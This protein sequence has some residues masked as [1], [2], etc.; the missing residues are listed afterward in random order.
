MARRRVVVSFVVAVLAVLA[1]PVLTNIAT[2]ELPDQL[3]PYLKW[4]WVVLL[5]VSIP[6]IAQMARVTTSQADVDFMMADGGLDIVIGAVPGVDPF[7]T[8]RDECIASLRE[9]LEAHRRTAVQGFG[10]VGK[11]QLVARYI[12]C[13]KSEYDFIW[14]LRAQDA[15][16]AG[17]DYDA[18]AI[19]KSL[20]ADRSTRRFATLNWLQRNSRWLLIFDDAR[21]NSQIDRFLS[22]DLNGHVIIISRERLDLTPEIVEVKD[23]TIEESLHFLSEIISEPPQELK[24]LAVRLAGVPLALRQAANYI[25]TAGLSI[26]QYLDML[27]RRPKAVI[28]AGRVSERSETIATV[29]KLSIGAANREAPGAKK[30]LALCSLYA[31][32]PIPSHLPQSFGQRKM[33]TILFLPSPIEAVFRR[34]LR[35]DVYYSRMVAA[36]TRHLLL[37]ITD[38]A[39][40]VHPLIAD[41]VRISQSAASTRKF[42]YFAATALV[43]LAGNPAV[44]ADE[45]LMDRLIPHIASIGE[46]ADQVKPALAGLSNFSVRV[47][48]YCWSAAA[49]ALYFASH[50]LQGQDLEAGKQ[51]AELALKLAERAN[52]PSMAFRGGGEPSSYFGV[53]MALEAVAFYAGREGKYDV[54]EGYLRR[55]IEM[56]RIVPTTA[57]WI[58]GQL[59]L[60]MLSLSQQGKNEEARDLFFEKWGLL[61]HHLAVDAPERIQVLRVFDDCSGC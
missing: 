14:W 34:R 38:S 58:T 55:G 29:W 3:R 21:M 15:A 23:W 27:S 47:A 53:F 46:A 22:A 24:R 5:I 36:L 12:E 41:T 50:R 9:Q 26:Q 19:A 40:R 37:T 8:G 56:M 6:V 30:L 39:L 7:F 33:R 10:G 49:E 1:I 20:P 43:E 60:L 11:S 44:R 61:S 32:G 42:I 45:D 2:G 16:A 48:W 59:V 17:L 28:K 35:N 13:H 54:A 31:D 18:I 52:A 57:P 51:L 4:T 25:A